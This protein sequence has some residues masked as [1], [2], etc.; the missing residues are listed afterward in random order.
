VILAALIAVGWYRPAAADERVLRIVTPLEVRTLDPYQRRWAAER[1][2]TTMMLDGLTRED[3]NGDPVPGAAISWDISSD[4]RQY[5]FHLRPD[6]AFSDGK[7]VTASDFVYAFRRYVDPNTHSQSTGA[8]ESVLHARDALSGRMSPDTLGV[9]ATDSLTLTVTLAHPSPF[10]LHWATLLVPLESEAI[11]R[12]HDKWTEPGHMVSNGP[13]IVSAFQPSGAI[14]LVKNPKYWNA[15][16]IRLDRIKM[17]PVPDHAQALTMFNAGELDVLNLTDEQVADQRDALGDRIKIQPQNRVTYYFFNMAS[18]P[19][20]DQPSLRRAL[21]LTFEPEVI[22]RKLGTPTIEPANSIIPRNFPA[23]A[24]P[25]LDFAARPMADRLAE[26]HR[27]YAEAHYGPQRPLTISLVD[28]N[29]K[30]CQIVA[31]MWKAAL[32]VQVNCTIIPEDEARFSASSSGDYDMGLMSESAAAP[33]PLELLES[34]Q[35]TPMN[36]GNIGRYRNAKFDA[37]LGEAA[38]SADFLARSE[39]L[40][41]AERIVLDDL[42]A[43]PLAYYRVVYMVNPRVKGFRM[44]P[45]GSM[46]VDGASIEQPSE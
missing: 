29:R 41:R 36:F 1:V 44:L 43:L 6:A 10:F 18:G 22:A 27:L 33:D 42:P 30:R 5:V 13:F 16:A 11:E 38:D 28:G 37:L 46:F 34:F 20:A 45:S 4:G 25:R 21:A 26:A 24:H 7:A 14:E 35:S 8:I 17:I 23:Y 15:T 3:G 2:V 31:D 32:G 39:K 9:T 19:L 40:A 12:W